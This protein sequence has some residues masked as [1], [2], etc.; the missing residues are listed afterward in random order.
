MIDHQDEGL[1]D[2][3]RA[4]GMTPICAHILMKDKA[5]KARLAR[6]VV[7]LCLAPAAAEA[8]A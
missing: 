5:D 7:D 3:I 2:E 1:G 4:H 8:V 6:E